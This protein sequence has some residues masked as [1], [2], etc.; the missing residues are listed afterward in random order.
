ML[1]SMVVPP[2]KELVT[3]HADK[4]LRTKLDLGEGA[5]VREYRIDGRSITEDDI[6]WQI[7]ILGARAGFI[8]SDRVRRALRIGKYTQADQCK[9]QSKQRRRW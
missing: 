5:G 3:Q 2:G 4:H 6:D 1:G 9:F 8:D 7:T